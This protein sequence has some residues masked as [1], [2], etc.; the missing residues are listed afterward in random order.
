MF[1]GRGM[2]WFIPVLFFAITVELEVKTYLVNDLR[3]RVK[4]LED[5]R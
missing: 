2:Y 3:K 4:A 5:L 1:H